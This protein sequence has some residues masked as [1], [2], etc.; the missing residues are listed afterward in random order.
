MP[1]QETSIVHANIH[2]AHQSILHGTYKHSFSH[3]SISHSTYTHSF[4]H[5]SMS[6]STYKHTFC[7]QKHIALHTQNIHTAHQFT[8]LNQDLRYVIRAYG[9]TLSILLIHLRRVVR[10]VWV[11]QTA[12][13]IDANRSWHAELCT[14][15]CT[16]GVHAGIQMH[17]V[18]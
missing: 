12:S 9:F 10:C 11:P 18:E 1:I 16:L 13:I 7:T 2:Y 3:R 6:H 17:R 8:R 5:Q 4:S 14:R 15:R